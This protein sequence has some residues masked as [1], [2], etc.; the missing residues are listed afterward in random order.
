MSE[1]NLSF[2]SFFFLYEA[3]PR[4]ERPCHKR[5]QII[6]IKLHANDQKYA[7]EYYIVYVLYLWYHEMFD[8]ISI[9]PIAIG[10]FLNYVEFFLYLRL[11]F[12]RTRRLSSLLE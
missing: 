11:D 1:I 7:A 8:K 3:T 5:R 9:S 2:S 12:H 6:M 10:L 4:Q